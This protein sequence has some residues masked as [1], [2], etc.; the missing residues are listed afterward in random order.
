MRSQEHGEVSS[1]VRDKNGHIDE[2]HNQVMSSESLEPSTHFDKTA[3]IKYMEKQHQKSF[4]YF[5]KDNRLLSESDWPTQQEESCGVDTDWLTNTLSYLIGLFS[6]DL[7]S[8]TALDDTRYQEALIL[9]SERLSTVQDGLPRE[10]QFSN[11]R[12][13]FKKFATQKDIFPTLRKM[14]ELHLCS[15]WGHEKSDE[16]T[17]EYSRLLASHISLI[18]VN[19]TDSD[20]DFGKGLIGEPRLL[21]VLIIFVHSKGK[22]YFRNELQDTTEFVLL[23]IIQLFYNCSMDYANRDRLRGAG[24]LEAVIPFMESKDHQMALVALLCV[25]YLADEEQ[26]GVFRANNVAPMRLLLSRIREAAVDVDKRDSMGW[27][28]TELLKGLG[29][30]ALNDA[31]KTLIADAEFVPILLV[32]AKEDR[33]PDEQFEAMDILWTLSFDETARLITGIGNQKEAIGLFG[34]L[35]S[36]E[37]HPCKKTAEGILWNIRGGCP[38]CAVPQEDIEDNFDK[39]DSSNQPYI[40]MS[41]QWDSQELVLRVRDVLRSRGYNVWID[42]E[43][44]A[45]S[46]LEAMARAVEGAHVVL[47]FFSKRYKDSQNC[48]AEAEYTFKTK[49]PFIPVLVEPNYAADGWL[50]IM[51]GVKL[52]YD[53]SREDIIADKMAELG[54]ALDCGQQSRMAQ[55]GPDTAINVTDGKE[56]KTISTKLLSTASN[57]CSMASN[58]PYTTLHHQPCAFWREHIG[59]QT[60]S[61]KGWDA[62][63]VSDWMKESSLDRE[64]LG[65]LTGRHLHFLWRMKQ[66]APSSYYKFI[67]ENLRLTNIDHMATLTNALEEL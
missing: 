64:K 60:P 21:E 51:L 56:D 65:H 47:L 39:T 52:Y 46:T 12:R 67:E 27:H 1:I 57:A 13:L 26:S 44:M 22:N 42:V 34:R 43:R 61:V 19:G 49:K 50:G 5:R 3:S 30:L 17:K 8:E 54:K 40:M 41:Y 58:S 28:A 53:F 20:V 37:S 7:N 29:R 32:M 10:T 45:G 4:K 35:A 63:M 6:N 9:L 66:D 55:E 25:A 14:L 36:N 11:R 38:A 33:Y 18:M 31:N 62:G 16:E 23:L 15:G 24:V 2:G 59:S 48:R